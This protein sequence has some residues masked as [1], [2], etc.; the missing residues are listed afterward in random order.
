MGKIRIPWD[1]D[2]ILFVSRQTDS[3]LFWCRLEVSGEE[4]NV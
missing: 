2:W 4:K 1:P 3:T